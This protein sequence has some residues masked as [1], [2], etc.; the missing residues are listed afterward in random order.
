M[1]VKLYMKIDFQDLAYVIVK[2]VRQAWK[3][4]GRLKKG[5]QKAQAWSETAFP[6]WN[7][8]FFKEDLVLFLRLF[9]WLSQPI[10]I[11]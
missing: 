2:S 4:Q 8:F 10:Q 6:R 3:P 7:F 11:I 9:N 5:N 1:Y